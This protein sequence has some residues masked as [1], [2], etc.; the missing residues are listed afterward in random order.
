[1][2]FGRRSAVLALAFEDGQ[3]TAVL[4]NGAATPVVA[5]FAVD[6]LLDDPP[7]VGQELRDC[8]QPLGRL[9]RRA[10]VG[11]PLN[12]LMVT[13]VAVPALPD[14]ALAGFLRIQ[15]EREFLLAPEDLAMGVSL[16]TQGDGGRSALLVALPVRHYANLLRAL[17]LAG[18]RALAVVPT[19]TA[20]ADERL[21]EARLVLGA[22]SCDLLVTA[23]GGLV[24]LRR[25]A[26]AD[27]DALP[28]GADLEVLPG[29]VRISLRQLPAGTRAELK[30]LAVTGSAAAS[31]AAVL[32]LQ[33]EADADPWRPQ[34]EVLGT[35]PAL[36]C[37]ARLA[38]L[39]VGGER[40][41]LA[42]LPIPV[43][44][45]HPWL[46]G[47]RPRQLAAAAGV[48]LALLLAVLGAVLRQRWQLAATQA[49]WSAMETRVE[50]IR[51]LMDDAA[52]H[53]AW[54]SDQPESLDVLRA[55]TL[56]F[57]ERGTVWATRLEL[58][59]RR[60]VTLAGKATSREA[61]FQTLAALRQ[62]PSVREVRVSQ[63]RSAAD[64]KSPMTFTLSFTW[65]PPR[66]V[67][68]VAE[69]TR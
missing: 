51:T 47:W 58:K 46:W 45:L 68:P 39:A 53:A 64:G 69:E 38:A 62:T 66:A 55:V 43:P 12:R 25:I 17:R 54:L 4:A 6:P 48:L 29:E 37:C 40:L 24:L 7:L 27:S 5:S 15:A 1:M 52:A 2:R 60:Q 28:Q 34:A 23:G 21:A 36:R 35:S 11:L 26:G 9:P 65:Q 3:L 14:E 13:T 44:R 8:L 56:A 57:P 63:A 16:S 49:Q 10:V 41:P 32:A 50:A 31:A 30:V 61:W 20:L 18:L 42:L 19:L 22:R 59:D 67:R 33:E